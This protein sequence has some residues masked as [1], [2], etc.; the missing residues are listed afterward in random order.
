MELNHELRKQLWD[1]CEDQMAVDLIR[2][3]KDAQE[4]SK[5]LLDHALTVRDMICNFGAAQIAAD[6]LYK[7]AACVRISRRII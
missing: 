3:L 6:Y 4:A 7:H 5:I 2:D 1:V